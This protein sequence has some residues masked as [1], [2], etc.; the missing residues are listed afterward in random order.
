MIRLGRKS[1]D[2]R[3]RVVASPGQTQHRHVA[4][5][6]HAGVVDDD[7]RGN[8]AVHLLPSEQLVEWH[9]RLPSS[10]SD[11]PIRTVT[12]V[13]PLR[14]TPGLAWNHAGPGELPTSARVHP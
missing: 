7:M 5:S 3:E 6:A 14:R 9:W 11:V 12:R 13:G 10:V 4:V 8:L 1:Q 2:N